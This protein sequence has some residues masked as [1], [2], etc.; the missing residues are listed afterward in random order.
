M[1]DTIVRRYRNWKTYNETC[2]ELM[3][4]SNRELHDLGIRRGDIPYIARRT[5][6]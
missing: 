6:R 5:S 3:Q 2:T 1:F 4:L